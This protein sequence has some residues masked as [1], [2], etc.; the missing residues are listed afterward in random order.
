MAPSKK[1]KANAGKASTSKANAAKGNA[2]KMNTARA[3]TAKTNAVKANT[4]K[5]NTNKRGR[6]VDDSEKIDMPPA[7]KQTVANNVGPQP[8]ESNS[9]SSLISSQPRIPEVVDLDDEESIQRFINPKPK[10]IGRIKPMLKPVGEF[11]RFNDGDVTI[12]LVERTSK[13]TYQLHGNILGRASSWFEKVL[14]LNM[15]GLEPDPVMIANHAVAGML[16]ARFELEYCPKLKLHI[17]ARRSIGYIKEEDQNYGAPK[18]LAPA[19]TDVEDDLNAETHLTPLPQMLQAVESVNVV[20]AAQIPGHP[21]TG[22]DDGALR[23]LHDPVVEEEAVAT[24]S[25]VLVFSK[26]SETNTITEE[27]EPDADV[28]MVD[29]S[30]NGLEITKGMAGE[31]FDQTAQ[32]QLSTRKNE[33]ST[34]VLAQATEEHPSAEEE[35]LA[36]GSVT[37]QK[38]DNDITRSVEAVAEDHPTI[39]SEPPSSLASD[40]TIE[41]PV[42]KKKVSPCLDTI[43]EAE[44]TVM[45]DGSATPPNI[46]STK[47]GLDIENKMSDDD[48]IMGHSFDVISLGAI[49][50]LVEEH[51]AHHIYKNPAIQDDSIGCPSSLCIPQGDSPYEEIPKGDMSSKPTNSRLI[52]QSSSSKDDQRE[53]PVSETE[54]N[55]IKGHN[56][57]VLADSGQ[58]TATNNE[59]GLQLQTQERQPISDKF[60]QSSTPVLAV[61]TLLAD[62]VKAISII[63]SDKP[64][65]ET[66][67]AYNNLF[68]IYYSRAPVIDS[69]DIDVAFQQSHLLIEVARLYGSIPLVR[70]Y[71]NSALMLFGRDLYIA[72][73]ADPP[74]WIQLS[75]YLESAPIFQESLIHIVANYPYWP[76]P[77]LKLDELYDPIFEIIE[78]KTNVFVTSKENVN[79]KLFSNVIRDAEV[80]SRPINKDSFDTWFVEQYWRDWFAKSMAKANKSSDDGKKCARGKVYREIYKSGETYLPTILV[81]DAVEACRSKDFSTKSKRQGIEQDLKTL[82]DFAQN[83]VQALCANHSMLSVEDVGIDYLTCIKVEHNEL[84]WVKSKGN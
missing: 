3:N 34:S 84:P 18:K 66:L 22:D 59:S 50:G 46:D 29:T 31:K 21:V 19:P 41:D 65:A 48:V 83:E 1:G 40:P 9:V 2:G 47:E 7:K 81:L 39:E 73:T 12:E 55:S 80:F 56:K 16:W 79:R 37:D 71:I 76:W 51:H 57:S 13:F 15:V 52:R 43:R 68:L 26:V 45:Y 64:S 30:P 36:D 63:E 58:P 75:M 33:P 74:C 35:M 24:E 27:L 62:N 49:K 4:D 60:E 23:D 44:A 28:V 11:P 54:E 67:L 8:D 20:S 69:Q 53:P 6:Q 5:A 25:S 14:H 78:Q 42:V 17:L 72:I 32:D 61:P 70:P 77:S 38:Q 82:K 10:K